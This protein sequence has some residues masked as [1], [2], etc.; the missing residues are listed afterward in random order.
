MSKMSNRI[1]VVS[2][3]WFRAALIGGIAFSVHSPHESVS[4]T[5]KEAPSA[6]VA[7]SPADEEGEPLQ[8]RG[9]VLDEG[10]RPISKAS[11]VAHH[12]DAGGL[13]NP[14]G[15]ATRVPRLRG[16][17]VT[18]GAGRFGFVTI[19]PAPYPNGSEPAHIHVT[20]TV[21]AHHVRHLEYWFEDDPLVTPARRER[22]RGN[23]AIVVVTP[24]RDPN[25]VWTFSHDIRLEGN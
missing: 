12:T 8:F 11:V 6:F 20:V 23:P 19:R 10:G 24:E 21:P 25:G 3:R 14:R 9:R 16:V 7:L 4:Q 2:N 13:Y 22:A 5:A 15:S 17:A 1:R 18:D